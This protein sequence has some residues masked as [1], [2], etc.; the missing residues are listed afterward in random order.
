V[1]FSGAGTGKRYS[2]NENS[3]IETGGSGASY[4]PGDVAGSAAN[5]G[6]YL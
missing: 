4:F 3:V 5:G 1:T 2:V 6:Q